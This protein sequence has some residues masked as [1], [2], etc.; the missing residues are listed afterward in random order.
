MKQGYINDFLSQYVSDGSVVERCD[1]VLE[2]VY[3]ILV[4]LFLKMLFGQER[5]HFC[6]GFACLTSMGLH[7]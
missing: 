3:I 2:T 7:A 6:V 5:R 4:S 1:N